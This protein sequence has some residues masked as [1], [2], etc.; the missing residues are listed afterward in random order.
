M[1]LRFQASAPGSRQRVMTR[2]AE[3]FKVRHRPSQMVLGF[4]PPDVLT[5]HL[6][7]G[8][9]RAL[10]TDTRYAPLPLTALNPSHTGFRPGRLEGMPQPATTGASSAVLLSCTSSS[11]P[12]SFFTVGWQEPGGGDPSRCW[13]QLRLVSR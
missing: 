9:H 2:D 3:I 11:S 12:L 1:V 5:R 13:P 6:N 10:T 4:R 8:P 7:Q